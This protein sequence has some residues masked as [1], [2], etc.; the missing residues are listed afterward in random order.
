ML[1]MGMGKGGGGG[2]MDVGVCFQFE[3]KYLNFNWEMFFVCFRNYY[4]EIKWS[5][6]K[7]KIFGKFESFDHQVLKR[8]KKSRITQTK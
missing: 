2:G 3:F 8:N 7:M 1:G 4:M 6:D 5:F